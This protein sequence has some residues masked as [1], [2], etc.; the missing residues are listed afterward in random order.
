[1]LGCFVGRAPGVTLTTVGVY[2]ACVE[3]AGGLRKVNQAFNPIFAPVVAGLTADGDQ[4]NAALVFS[5]VSQWMLWVLVP[6]VAALAL[7][8]P[9]ILG[10]Y[11]AV[12]RQGGLWL[13]IVAVACATNAF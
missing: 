10:I 11:G 2:G 7:A 9:M 3:V 12:F 1:M 8:G 13:A 5:R 6:L 4:G